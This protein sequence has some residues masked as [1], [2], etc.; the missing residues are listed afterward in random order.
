MIALSIVKDKINGPCFK[1]DAGELF[2]IV[3]V[4]NQNADDKLKY[5]KENNRDM[6]EGFYYKVKRVLD[7]SEGGTGI[8]KFGKI[9]EIFSKYID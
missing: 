4:R 5:L 3:G 9:E 7:T 6:K 2:K 8:A 1:L